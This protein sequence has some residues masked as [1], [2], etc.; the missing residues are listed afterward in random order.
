MQH[1]PAPERPVPDLHFRACKWR[2]TGH[3][4]CLGAGNPHVG[5]AGRAVDKHFEAVQSIVAVAL[6]VGHLNGIAFHFSVSIHPP[7]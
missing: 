2:R 3:R 4:L 1:A 5:D 7:F 6:I